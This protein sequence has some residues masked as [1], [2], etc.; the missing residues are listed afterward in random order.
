MCETIMRD[1]TLF[2]SFHKKIQNRADHF[3]RLP[4]YSFRTLYNT[5][6]AHKHLYQRIF[7]FPYGS[8]PLHF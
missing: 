3:I 8:K 6:K 2:P 4:S 1:H 5:L 7:I